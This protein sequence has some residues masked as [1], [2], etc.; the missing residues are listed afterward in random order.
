MKYTPEFKLSIVKEA[1][2]TEQSSRE[3]AKK[4]NIGSNTTILNWVNLYKERGES[5][6]Y[7]KEKEKEEKVEEKTEVPEKKE[8]EIVKVDCEEKEVEEEKN[9]E[10]NDAIETNTTEPPPTLSSVLK[11]SWK[12]GKM[13]ARR[14]IAE[15]KSRKK[16]KEEEN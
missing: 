12:V 13:V 15:F 7:E 5:C 6:F 16:R 10:V 14:K 8:E 11:K 2:E 9:E 4:Y 1:I 3:L